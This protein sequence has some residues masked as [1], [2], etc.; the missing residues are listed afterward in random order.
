MVDDIFH[1]WIQILSS[2]GGIARYSTGAVSIGL[3]FSTVYYYYFLDTEKH[4]R[5]YKLL[6]A[7]STVTI[8]PLHCVIFIQT[9]RIWILH[10]LQLYYF[11]EK[12]KIDVQLGTKRR[13]TYPV[14]MF[15]GRLLNILLMYQ[16]CQIFVL[17]LAVRKEKFYSFTCMVS[18]YGWTEYKEMRTK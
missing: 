11:V 12:K 2:L 9:A 4:V 15:S 7:D 16:C 18:S 3:D 8:S 17:K 1:S 14:T 10:S 5:K 13:K 6:D